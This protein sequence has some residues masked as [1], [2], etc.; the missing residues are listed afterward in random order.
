ADELDARD[1]AAQALIDGDALALLTGGERGAGARAVTLRFHL[2][3]PGRVR[4]VVDDPAAIL[5]HVLGEV[6]R[7]SVRVVEGEQEPAVDRTAA[8]RPLGSQVLVD[9]PPA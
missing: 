8:A 6:P 1:L 2:G 4:L 9:P 7:E 3:V 5:Q